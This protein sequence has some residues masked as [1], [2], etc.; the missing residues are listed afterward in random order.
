MHEKG[1]LCVLEKVNSLV[2]EKVFLCETVALFT[3]A[4]PNT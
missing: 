2:L 1:S 4:T 3:L